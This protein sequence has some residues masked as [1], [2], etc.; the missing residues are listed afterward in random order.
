MIKVQL[1]MPTLC[2]RAINKIKHSFR[3]K[4]QDAQ[5]AHFL[6]NFGEIIQYSE[7]EDITEALQQNEIIQM[8]VEI[9]LYYALSIDNN[10]LSELGDIAS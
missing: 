8:V 10:V 1:S 3:C 5:T 6:P 4:P 2:P 7:P 9:F